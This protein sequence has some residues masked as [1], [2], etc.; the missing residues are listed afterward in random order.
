MDE[1]IP[2]RRRPG[3]SCEA[4]VNQKTAAE[5]ESGQA[6]FLRGGRSAPS[7]AEQAHRPARGFGASQE[8]EGARG[9]LGGVATWAR[10]RCGCG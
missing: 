1:I 4:E 8:R 7:H 2:N 6:R 9:D 5:S 10:P 3:N